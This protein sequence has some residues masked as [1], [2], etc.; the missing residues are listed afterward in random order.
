MMMLIGLARVSSAEP[1]CAL[2]RG[3]YSID[4]ACLPAVSRDGR[5]LAVPVVDTDGSRGLPNLL[6]R[7]IA[8]DGS[9]PELLAV[10]ATK[11]VERVG[12]EI[13][14]ALWKVVAPRIDQVNARLATG[15]FSSLPKVAMPKSE[16]DSATQKLALSSA[17]LDVVHQG[18]EF[19]VRRADRVVDGFLLPVRGCGANN[20]AYLDELRASESLLMM[21]VARHSP[22]AACEDPSLMGGGWHLVQLKPD[23]K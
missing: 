19:E 20:Y 8:L 18:R 14:A 4:Y 16:R 21:H 22:S 15:K 12:G 9:R 23:E 3:A 5:E 2:T 7:F 6:V 11:E 17:K 10:L 1:T 13:T